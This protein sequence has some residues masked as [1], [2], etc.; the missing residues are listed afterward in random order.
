MIDNVVD[1]IRKDYIATPNQIIEFCKN[2]VTSMYNL[3]V[4]HNPSSVE[5]G[6][7]LVMRTDDMHI[8]ATHGLDGDIN[9]HITIRKYDGSSDE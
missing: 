4:K 7:P 5:D 3:N 1:L 9:I 8:L 2:I 6:G